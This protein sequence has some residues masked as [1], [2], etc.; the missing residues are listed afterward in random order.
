MTAAIEKNGVLPA[1]KT[2]VA[3]REPIAV[4]SEC[5]RLTD[6][7]GMVR[8]RDVFP[9][10]AVAVDLHCGSAKCADG[11][12]VG[13]GEIRV[14]VERDDRVCGAFAEHMDI[15]AFALD[16]DAFGIG[17]GFHEN[18]PARR[19]RIGAHGRDADRLLKRGELTRT[20]ERD[21]SVS[22]NG[23]VGWR[24]ANKNQEASAA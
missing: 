20:V 11:F 21:D 14:E 10:H 8:D 5:E 6:R 2:A 23:D 24:G 4:G 12:A 19:G 3:K 13:P 17:A 9:E 22:A 15:A 1:E 7:P 16:V 18:Y